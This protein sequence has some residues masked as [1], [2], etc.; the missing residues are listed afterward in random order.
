QERSYDLVLMDCQMPVLDGYQATRRIR[1]LDD[2]R[3]KELPIVALTANAMKG[4]ED[5]CYAAGMDDYLPKP[6]HPEELQRC[7]DKWLGGRMA[8]Q[9]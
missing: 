5:K 2:A 6:I 3:F 8:A 4:D 9:Q 1:S 7:V